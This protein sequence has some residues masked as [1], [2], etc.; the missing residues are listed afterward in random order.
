MIGFDKSMSHY[1]TYGECGKIPSTKICDIMNDFNNA[2]GVTLNR[3]GD[4]YQC[5]F[6]TNIGKTVSKDN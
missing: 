5:E 2:V 1:L 4:G 3:E 6:E